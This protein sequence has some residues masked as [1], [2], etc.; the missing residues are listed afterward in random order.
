[1][2]IALVVLT[3]ALLAALY[4]IHRK[5]ETI[6]QLLSGHHSERQELLNRIQAPREAVA[7]SIEP[8][9]RRHYRSE[10]DEERRF[11][12]GEVR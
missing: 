8:D 10:G 1:M 11:L 7:Q 4:L 3:V 2:T 12:T 5:D 6:E 9:D